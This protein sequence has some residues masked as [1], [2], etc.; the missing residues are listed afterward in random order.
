MIK[1]RRESATQFRA[2]NRPELAEKEESE[3]TQLEQYLPR[4][5]SQPEIEKIVQDTIT[6]VKALSIKDM[7]VLMNALRPKLQGKADMAIVSA[8]VKAKLS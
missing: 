8:A 5:L 4:Q 6:E 7:G 1:Q 3:I 2:G